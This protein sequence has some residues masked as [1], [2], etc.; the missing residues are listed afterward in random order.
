MAANIVTDCST[1]KSR[2]PIKVTETSIK[3]NLPMNLS[4]LKHTRSSK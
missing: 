3:G 2:K 1:N 4:Q